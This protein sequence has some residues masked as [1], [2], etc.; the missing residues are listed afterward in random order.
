M[1]RI[2]EWDRDEFMDAAARA[3][4]V[5]AW[6]DAAEEQ[7]E[8]LSGELMDQAP[9]TPPEA[10]QAAKELAVAL[11]QSNGPLSQLWDKAATAKGKHSRDPT[12]EDFGHYLAM[13]ALGHGVSWEDDHPDVGIKLPSMEFHADYEE[14]PDPEDE[15]D[16]V[17]GYWEV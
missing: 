12:V 17:V 16:Y 4:W 2:E 1:A 6:A 9:E 8:T 10:K 5:Q 15:G 3:L 14:P 11:E 7:G 13:G